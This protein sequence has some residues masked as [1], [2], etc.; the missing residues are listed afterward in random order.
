MKSQ[1]D[2]E[3]TYPY[4][5]EQVWAALTDKAAISQWLMRTDDFEPRLGHK[6]RL[7]AKPMPGW[8]GWVDCEILE[9]TPPRL[10]SYRWVGDENKAPMTVTWS[11]EPTSDGTRLRLVHTGFAGIGG[12]MLAR[13]LMGPGWKKMMRRRIPAVLAHAA[14][15][16]MKF[17]PGQR[18]ADLSH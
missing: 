4:A 17:T 11:L 13:L 10:I 8:R 18:L 15:H 16:G 14:Q 3:Q 6:F 2:L 12:F 9:L 1:I 7:T 5:I